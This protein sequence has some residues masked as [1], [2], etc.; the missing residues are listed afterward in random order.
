MGAMKKLKVELPAEAIAEY[1]KLV[2]FE[3]GLVR[4][5]Q[6]SYEYAIGLP[7]LDSRPDSATLRS[8]RT[9]LC[10]FPRTRTC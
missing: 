6:V 10:A 7:W 3:M 4:M 8:R 9:H 5:G 1:K 2:G